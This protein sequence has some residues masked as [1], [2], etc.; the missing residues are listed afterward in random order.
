MC[1]KKFIVANLLKKIK[2]VTAIYLYLVLLLIKK[3]CYNTNNMKNILFFFIMFLSIMIV[4]AQGLT[5]EWMINLNISEQEIDEYIMFKPNN[6]KAY[7]NY[8]T[9]NQNKTFSTYTRQECGSSCYYTTSGIYE[10][11]GENHIR[12]IIKSIL[13]S[14]FC[15]EK[16][17][18]PNKDIGLYYINREEDR[19]ILLKSNGNIEND[20]QNVIYSKMITDFFNFQRMFP[21]GNRI[22]SAKIEKMSEKDMVHSYLKK[23][24]YTDFEYLFS[25]NVGYG[26]FS[27]ITI[28]KIEGEFQYLY[29]DFSYP[30]NYYL[31]IFNYEPIK[32]TDRLVD[33]IN[34]D[35]ELK[36]V[37]LDDSSIS[38]SINDFSHLKIYTKSEKKLV[39]KIIHQE[40][41]KYYDLATIYYLVNEIPIYIEQNY[42]MKRASDRP[43]QNSFYIVDWNTN[44][45]ILKKENYGSR[46]FE[47]EKWEKIIELSKESIKYL[48][49]H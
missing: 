24:G 23:I 44:K 46:K 2:L 20:K 29:L 22:S 9:L 41:N 10:M 4:K 42:D 14:R 38:K 49:V 34:S 28:A 48:N 6:K 17:Y 27:K 35:N 31:S 1:A 12:F 47:K 45:Y 30:N 8:I 43:A 5:G 37:N 36:V 15:E 25:K 26:G 19:M 21:L 3:L 11:V 32:K 39:E 40:F 13:K 7:G 33:K 16:D 18:N